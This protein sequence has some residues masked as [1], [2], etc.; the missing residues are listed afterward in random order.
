MQWVLT[1]L[2]NTM[3]CQKPCRKHEELAVEIIKMT[4]YIK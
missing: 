1:D 2:G 3:F 4:A